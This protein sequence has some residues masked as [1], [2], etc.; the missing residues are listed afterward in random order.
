MR[1]QRNNEQ[2]HAISDDCNYLGM[3]LYT[4]EPTDEKNMKKTIEDLQELMKVVPTMM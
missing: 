3:M 1:I 4:V 2:E